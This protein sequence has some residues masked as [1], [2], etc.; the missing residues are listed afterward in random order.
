MTSKRAVIIVVI[1]LL[2]SCQSQTT[3]TIKMGWVGPLTGAATSYGIPEFN[4][5]KMAVET[6]NADGGID[7]KQIELI[8]EDGRCDAASAVSAATKLIDINDVQILLGGHCSTESMALVPLSSEKKVI[9]IA[10]ATGTDAF[11]G[12]GQYAFRTFPSAQVL[13]SRL[14]DVA[15]EQGTRSVVT[16]HEEKDWPKSVIGAFAKQFRSLGGKVVAQE[17]FTSGTLDVRTPL[18]KLK[19]ADPDAIMISVQ[20]PDAA[21]KIIDQLNELGLDNLQIYGDAIVVSVP[22]YN[23]TQGKLPATALGALP[24]SSTAYS[25]RLKTF[26]QEYEQVYGE[27]ATNPYYASEGYDGVLIAAEL[28][29]KCQGDAECM[30]SE[31]VSR[32]W[33]GMTGTFTFDENGDPSPFVGIAHVENG[34]LVFEGE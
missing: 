14:A 10:G 21:A 9:M 27:L 15:Y 18:L 3:D 17:S 11:T 33:E 13:Y 19:Q 4:G 34:K 12:V 22:T 25:E 32:S 7:G 8:T 1:A 6:I 30:R 20:G 16:L 31:L 26:V 29:K 28:I 24:H 23:K 2:A 5:A